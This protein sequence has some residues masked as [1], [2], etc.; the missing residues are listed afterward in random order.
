MKTVLERF[1]RDGANVRVT[2]S[3]I[4]DGESVGITGRIAEITHDPVNPTVTIEW[5]SNKP[6][7]PR[8]GRVTYAIRYIITA[9]RWGDQDN[10]GL[11]GPPIWP[12]LPGMH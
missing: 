7:V 9:Q 8:S 10:G 4:R 6:N 1:M 3:A 12:S 2:T 5:T 11:A